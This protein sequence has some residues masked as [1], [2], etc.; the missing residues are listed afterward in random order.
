MLTDGDIQLEEVFEK[1][2]WKVMKTSMVNDLKTL[3]GPRLP[4]FRAGTLIEDVGQCGICECVL[5]SGM[6]S[7]GRSRL[8]ELIW[9]DGKR[10][11]TVRLS[12]DDG[13]T[14][15]P[16]YAA[17]SKQP[18]YGTCVPRCGVIGINCGQPGVG[19]TRIPHRR[20]SCGNESL[21]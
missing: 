11:V 14:I 15:V 8:Q 17:I 9:F 3:I 13:G 2:G 20:K 19:E 1:G 18:P 6:A 4:E 16:I 21:F 10:G 7:M 5:L 12:T